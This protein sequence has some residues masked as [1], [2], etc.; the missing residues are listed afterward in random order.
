MVSILKVDIKSAVIFPNFLLILPKIEICIKF[1]EAA[2][3]WNG[4]P[5]RSAADV[6]PRIRKY[7][8]TKGAIA[9]KSL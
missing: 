7:I 1:S 4:I 8:R 6:M 3:V 5:P 2:I 9:S